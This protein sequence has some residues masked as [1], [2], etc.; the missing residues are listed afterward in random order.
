[1][2]LSVI[3]LSFRN[4][5]LLKFQVIASFSVSASSQ[6]YEGSKI[7]YLMQFLVI[8][9]QLSEAICPLENLQIEFT[10]T[11]LKNPSQSEQEKNTKVLYG[12]VPSYISILK[13]FS[14]P[15]DLIAPFEI[16]LARTVILRTP[17]RSWEIGVSRSFANI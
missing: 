3:Q 9:F 8:F 4:S 6:M 10:C 17:F 14:Y 2:F 1:M 16:T 13:V 12:R 15:K 7:S 5:N 11:A